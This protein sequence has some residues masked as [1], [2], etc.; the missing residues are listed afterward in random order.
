MG[1]IDGGEG[2]NWS[3]AARTCT[4]PPC[5]VGPMSKTCSQC[6][7]TDVH[8]AKLAGATIEPAKGG[9]VLNS[10]VKVD[11]LASACAAC[12]N[13]M[14]SADPEQLKMIKALG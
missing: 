13:I 4:L 6:H 10:M 9:M 3:R 2:R 8:S 12:G 1:D 5:T 11:V 7:S 14:L